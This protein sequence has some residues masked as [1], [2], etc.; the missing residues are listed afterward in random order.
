MPKHPLVLKLFEDNRI[1]KI[2]CTKKQNKG[3]LREILQLRISTGNP[4]F[5]QGIRISKQGK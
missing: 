3:K 5:K 1:A 4:Y 2:L